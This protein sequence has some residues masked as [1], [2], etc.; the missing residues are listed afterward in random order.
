M[1]RIVRVIFLLGLITVVS[2]SGV[3]GK[4]TKIIKF[5][6]KKELKVIMIT[7]RAMVKKEIHEFKTQKDDLFKSIKSSQEKSKSKRDKA[8]NQ[9]KSF[10]IASWNL[11][12]ISVNSSEYKLKTVNEYIRRLSTIQG[13]DIVFLQELRDNK[14]KSVENK[15][16]TYQYIPYFSKSLGEGKHKERYAILIHPK[17]LLKL[18]K[19][20][21]KVIIKEVQLRSFRNFKRPAFGLKIGKDLLVINVHLGHYG[22]GVDA[23]SK[24]IK[25]AKALKQS[26]AKLKRKY[27]VKNIIIAGDF[28]LN[29]ASLENIFTP[30]EYTISTRGKTTNKSSYDHVITSLPLRSDMISR[31]NRD[32]ISD[33]SPIRV[34]VELTK[35]GVRR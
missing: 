6:T 27:Q 12:N 2:N 11:H 24:R 19:L 34:K 31:I 3:I 5:F 21:R 17:M 14:K 7:S 26:I 29:V 10:A 1:K 13:T 25:E 33:H 9:K 28:N 35:I 4:G 16:K 8:K 15:L 30:F 32:N 22:N 18:K 23:V 20:G